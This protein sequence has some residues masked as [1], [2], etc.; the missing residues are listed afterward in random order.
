MHHED[1]ITSNSIGNHNDNRTAA[2]AS[3]S[4]LSDQLGDVVGQNNIDTARDK[5]SSLNQV[6]ELSEASHVREVEDLDG[7]DPL[8]C[9][10]I[11]MS[12][13]MSVD[14]ELQPYGVPHTSHNISGSHKASG[15]SQVV[16]YTLPP[17]GTALAG[18]PM[19]GNIDLD[20]LDCDQLMAIAAFLRL[21]FPTTSVSY[22]MQTRICQISI[23]ILMLASKSHL[24]LE[25]AQGACSEH[26]G[27]LNQ[28]GCEESIPEM[29]LT[30][31]NKGFSIG[32]HE[33][34]A[35]QYNSEISKPLK[36]RVQE[37]TGQQCP[38]DPSSQSWPVDNP[39]EHYSS[40]GFNTE[41]LRRL[42]EAE[43]VHNSLRKLLEYRNSL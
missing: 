23:D 3:N 25:Q 15:E 41:K 12:L 11:N 27:T 21:G 38:T 28:L 24:L 30:D 18:D 39:L 8:E 22:F 4:S 19:P 33:L 29:A 42:M 40:A 9:S 13:G 20:G 6:V 7:G 31:A 26:Q 14:Q 1:I 37:T 16:L 17:Q 35:S 10:S 2:P 43:K 5:D 32:L 36:G 34:G